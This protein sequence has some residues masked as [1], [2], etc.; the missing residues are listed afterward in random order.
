ME[1]TLSLNDVIY[2]SL[3]ALVFTWIVTGIV[4]ILKSALSKPL[5]LEGLPKDMNKIMQKCYNLFPNDIIQFRG[6]T[7]TRGMRVRV[8]TSQHKIF[9]GQLI[10]LNKD[11]MLC[12]LTKRYIVAHELDKIEEMNV[13]A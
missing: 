1:F 3:L 4:N 2:S 10:G 9:E 13:V 12:V 7:F 6:E 5:D 8:R 11:N